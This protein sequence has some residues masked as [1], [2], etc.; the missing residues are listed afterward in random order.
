MSSF[1]SIPAAETSSSDIVWRQPVLLLLN[2]REDKEAEQQHFEPSLQI[3]PE[4][5]LNI[6]CRN[7][8]IFGCYLWEKFKFS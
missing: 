7:T 8:K 1:F 3:N 5:K 2:A 6:D 4:H